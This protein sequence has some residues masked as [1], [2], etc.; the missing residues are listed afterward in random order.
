[1]SKSS[2]AS[3]RARVPARAAGL[4]AGAVLA[5][6]PLVAACGS[7][8]P[9]Q[10]VTAPTASESPPS[11]PAAA[12]S[13]PASA[14]PSS[15]AGSG[16][17]SLAACRTATLLITL[18]DGRASGTA[19]SVYY[20]LNFTNTSASAC[21]LYGYPGVSF[22]AAPASG[23]KQIGLAAQR[24]RGFAKM[25]VRLAPGAMAHTWLRVTLAANYP[26]SDCNPVTAHWLRVYPPGGA[27]AGYVGHDFSACA[28]TS[29]PL[30]S[31]LPVRAGAA[32]SGVTP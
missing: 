18:D 16:G 15:P 26:A 27:A 31:V 6:S 25:A 20:P 9:N 21:E 14:V 3:V 8:S 2:R 22:A 29:V 5:A 7:A 13:S 12:P 23:S 10:P 30:L 32:V 19:G 17:T 4:L 11:S 1:M 24:D 28:S